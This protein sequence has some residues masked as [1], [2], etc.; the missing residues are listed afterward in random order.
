M[1][2]HLGFQFIT[3]RRWGHLARLGHASDSGATA[4]GV[5]K[6]S[7]LTSTRLQ[8][9][10]HLR[11]PS[12]RFLSKQA[13]ST[14]RKPAR[15]HIDFAWRS[16]RP[17]TNRSATAGRTRSI[18]RAIGR[19]FIAYLFISLPKEKS[20][21]L[22]AIREQSDP[23]L[24]DDSRQS[25]YFTIQSLIFTRRRRDGRGLSGARR[26]TRPWRCN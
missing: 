19:T 5:S 1:V 20:A 26:E 18:W 3:K 22:V 25:N 2:K 12:K 17:L 8:L 9:P 14:L 21:S 6:A 16:S 15:E 13:A 10:L 24:T 23:Q 7:K 4:V 11:G